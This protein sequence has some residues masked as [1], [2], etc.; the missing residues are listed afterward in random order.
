MSGTVRVRISL[1]AGATLALGALGACFS[2]ERSTTGLVPGIPCEV[3]LE[4][5]NA[6][7]AIVAMRDYV[8]YPDS[9]S[10]P[11]GTTVSWV[12]C[13]PTTEDAHTTTSDVAGVWGSNLMS[14]GE[15]FSHEF[16]E[17]GVVFPYHCIPHQSI[18][19]VGT[20]VVEQR[21]P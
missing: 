16:T 18:G 5:I 20:V 8:F 19:M 7:H 9:I 13:A 6:G 17:A 14:T 3:P 1:A 2:E 21:T 10:V 12:N 11:V 15:F 4:L